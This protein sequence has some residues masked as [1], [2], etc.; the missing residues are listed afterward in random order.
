MLEIN[1]I[2][3]IDLGIKGENKAR[4]I[5]IDMNAWYTGHPN[6]SFSILHKRN[7]DETKSVT[8]ATFDRETGI[9]SWTPTSNDT[10][11]AGSGV[12][13]IRMTESDIRKKSIDVVTDVHPS[14]MN[15]SGET[16][17]SDWDGYLNA[18]EAEK[19]AA[20]AARVGAEAAQDA[21]ED[22]QDA[23]EEAQ[24]KAENAL[25]FAPR[26]SAETGHWMIWEASTERWVD[27]NRPA[28]G[29]TGPQ[30]EQGPEGA[31]G[32][33]GPQGVQGPQG[34]QGIQGIQG[35]A[36]PTGPQGMPGAPGANAVIMDIGPYKYSF[37]VVDGHL[38]CYYEGDEAPNFYINEQGHLIY[39]F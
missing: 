32:Q 11:Y 17:P 29:P 12:A 7:G 24:A 39:E 25:N 14:M 1:K 20:V 36:G 26:I 16:I 10:Y 5:Q 21:A 4:T 23:A 33:Q 15:G 27:T 18:V 2:Q 34:I 13:E 30:G 9:L 28:T 19:A 8:G 22:A 38:I 3:R 31:Q 6:A 35:P 37:Q